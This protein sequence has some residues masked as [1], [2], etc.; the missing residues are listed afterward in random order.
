MT[1]FNLIEV[2]STGIESVTASLDGKHSIQMS[3]EP[4]YLA[5][6]FFCGCEYPMES[7]A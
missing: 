2:S 6:W 4:I 5:K 7:S 1:G 3:Y